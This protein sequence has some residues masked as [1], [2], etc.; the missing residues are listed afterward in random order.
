MQLSN[1]TVY[2][3]QKAREVIDRYYGNTPRESPLCV[4]A[5]G[6]WLGFDL[7]HIDPNAQGV[8]F[9]LHNL[10]KHGYVIE[11]NPSVKNLEMGVALCIGHHLLEHV[12]LSEIEPEEIYSWGS[13][14][15]SL[16]TEMASVFAR[17]LLGGNSE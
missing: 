12:P 10:S 11:Y 13:L 4:F 5:I 1:H 14:F 7:L 3:V 8:E 9:R 17:E 15:S 6:H 2:A 16:E